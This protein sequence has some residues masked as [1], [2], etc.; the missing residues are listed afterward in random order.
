MTEAC[1]IMTPSQ[2]VCDDDTPAP[3]PALLQTALCY[4]MTRHT[5]RP[6]PHLAWNIV[7]HL[8]MLLSHPTVVCLPERCD[9]YRGLLKQ[10]EIIAIQEMPRHHLPDTHT[11]AIH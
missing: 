5:L 11:K 1:I 10:W 2:P 6:C 9:T 7:K 3:D 8:R 4:L